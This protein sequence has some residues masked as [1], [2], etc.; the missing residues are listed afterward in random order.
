MSDREILVDVSP[1]ELRA[2]VLQDGRLEHIEID[3]LGQPRLLQ[4][5]VLAPVTQV[6]QDLGAVFLDLGRQDGYLDK[7][8][9]PPPN[10]G[11]SLIVQVTAEAHR[12]KAA[13]VTVDPVL[14]G[15]L[16]D[17]TPTRPDHAIARAITAKRE[18]ARLRDILAR[19]V[20]ETVGALVHVHAR[21][22]ESAALEAEAKALLERW[23][24]IQERA[25]DPNARRGFRILDPAPDAPTR[26]RRIAPDALVREGR[27]GILF[28]ERDI[29]GALVSATHRRAQLPGGG[30]LIIDETEAL[31]AIDVDAGG[32]R[33]ATDNPSGFA[34]QTG[35][36][37]ARQMR[38][39]RLAGLIL[40]DFPR[41]GGERARRALV[42]ALEPALG[43]DGDVVTIHGW[44]RA[45]LLEV[46]R[47]RREPSLLEVLGSGET[48]NHFNAATLALE[49][50]R[51]V[52]RETSGIARPR[53]R[54]PNP[55]KLALEGPLRPALDQV[56][57]RLGAPLVLE[58]GEGVNAIEIT[59]DRR[60]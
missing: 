11:E 59:G 3:R 4:A 1:G 34:A 8:R 12:A 36:E 15:A 41:I 13:R 19:V 54:C 29:D 25:N 27:D 10:Q 17:L 60:E 22:V 26:A 14:A 51:R 53:L 56:E 49:A 5:T 7:F 21:D 9:G 52:C 6:R 33:A 16:L 24:G 37:I 35:L 30:A 31:V 32:D 43:R 50:L 18:R 55:V 46:T 58:A 44:T 38:L 40:I 20:P 39:R 45:G 57:S 47:T 28:Q 23:T 42:T 2:A 48:A